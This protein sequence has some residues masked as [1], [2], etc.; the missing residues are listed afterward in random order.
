MEQTADRIEAR[1]SMMVLQVF[2]YLQ[3]LDFLTTIL[4]LRLGLGEASPF[5]RLLTHWGP[6]FGVALSKVVALA[7]AGLALW[8][9]RQ[10]VIHLI[11][12]W[13]AGLVAWNLS[14][15]IYAVAMR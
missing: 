13:F 2:V 10:R 6:A 14:L 4:G 7:L 1:P 3:V 12:Y 8:L 15:M 11:N 9:N 5:I